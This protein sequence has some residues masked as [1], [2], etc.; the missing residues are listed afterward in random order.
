MDCK[1]CANGSD[2][3]F[4]PRVQKQTCWAHTERLTVAQGQQ[5]FSGL[6]NVTEGK[7]SFITTGL[8]LI[9]PVVTSTV[10]LVLDAF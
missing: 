9:Q 3:H 2:V 4:F 10:A 8:C 5:Q 1:I 6:Y 7:L